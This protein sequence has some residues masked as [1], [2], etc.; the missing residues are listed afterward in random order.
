MKRAAFGLCLFVG[1]VVTASAHDR[2]Q[3]VVLDS[4][5]AGGT[6]SDVL[7][8]PDGGV[9]VAGSTTKK[10]G[11]RDAVVAHLKVDDGTVSGPYVDVLPLPKGTEEASAFGFLGSPRSVIGSAVGYDGRTHT[12]VWNA[13]EDGTAGWSITQIPGRESSSIVSGREMVMPGDNITVTGTLVDGRGNHQGFFSY[14]GS[15]GAWTTGVLGGGTETQILGLASRRLDTDD[16]DDGLETLWAHGAMKITIEQGARPT[17]AWVPA[18][19]PLYV[20]PGSVIAGI[21]IPN[22]L[23]ARK[24]ANESAAVATLRTLVPTTPSHDLPNSAMMTSGFWPDCDNDGISSS[25]LITGGMRSEYDGR[26]VVGRA[27]FSGL[28]LTGTTS[29]ELSNGVDDDCDSEVDN[30]AAFSLVAPTAEEGDFKAVGV[31]WDRDGTVGSPLWSTVRGFVESARSRNNRM[32][33]PYLDAAIGCPVDMRHLLDDD[34]VS[35]QGLNKVDPSGIVL[36]Q[37]STTSSPGSPRPTLF[38][39]TGRMVPNERSV[40]V[41]TPVPDEGMATVADADDDLAMTVRLT[42]STSD[43]GDLAVEFLISSTKYEFGEDPVSAKV[44]EK[45]NRSNCKSTVR[46]GGVGSGAGGVAGGAVGGLGMIIWFYEWTE[47]KFV[48]VGEVYVEPGA[49]TTIYG[50]ATSEEGDFHNE[51]GQMRVRITG[52]STAKGKK[53]DVEVDTVQTEIVA[54]D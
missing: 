51:Y 2:Y 39:P 30:S 11:F 15:D 48:S 13:L 22:L 38:I 4:L 26:A 7:S 45:A 14:V 49:W 5:G 43:L 50:T 33:S 19:W 36:G 16:D 52:K 18:T 29:R 10:R 47:H 12:F 27:A 28:P 40:L 24:G 53:P 41:G 9:V 42:D 44:K 54:L 21:A 34:D 25:R 1:A 46:V 23:D 17:T 6:A 35:P 20:R 32:R 37:A 8:L 3:P 31:S